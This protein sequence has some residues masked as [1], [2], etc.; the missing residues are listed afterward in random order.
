[1]S[2]GSQDDGSRD[3]ELDVAES[4]TMTLTGYRNTSPDQSQEPAT[5]R[6]ASRLTG[7]Q[8]D[9]HRDIRD[10]GQ[11]AEQAAHGGA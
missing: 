7:E 8:P 1:M 11:D 3:E 10:P 9:V 6:M 5:Y 4:M 2:A